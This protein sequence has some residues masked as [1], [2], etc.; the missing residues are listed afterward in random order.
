MKSY[1]LVPPGA[2]PA[3]LAETPYVG[4]YHS[5]DLDSPCSAGNGHRLLVLMD[6][7]KTPPASLLPLPALLDAVTILG[8]IPAP[9]ATPAAAPLALLADVGGLATHTGYTLAKLLA[10]IH[11]TFAPS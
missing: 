9:A 3:E 7:S 10:T 5:I 8:S 6:Q 1:Y 4:E 2:L 11:P